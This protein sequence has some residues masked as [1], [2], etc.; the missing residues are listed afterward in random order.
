[1]YSSDREWMWPE[2][3]C[4]V[5]DFRAFLTTRC[6]A[7]VPTALSALPLVVSSQRTYLQRHLR[8]PSSRRYR[9]KSSL[10]LLRTGPSSFFGHEGSSRGAAGSTFCSPTSGCGWFGVEWRHFKNWPAWLRRWRSLIQ[11][12][13]A[14]PPRHE[15]GPRNIPPPPHPHGPSNPPRNLLK[16]QHSATKNEVHQEEFYGLEH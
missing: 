7:F 9:F 11:R 8:L 10:P 12:H 3:H 2:A 15:A 6:R 5:R 4:H 14:S 16:M 1:M 13:L